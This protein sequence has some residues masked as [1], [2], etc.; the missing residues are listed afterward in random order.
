[1]L[2]AEDILGIAVWRDQ[3]L[4][5]S[6]LVRP[7]GRFRWH[8]IGEVTGSGLTAGELEGAIADQLKPAQEEGDS[9]LQVQL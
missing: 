6:Y 9:A 4:S 2:G 5:S 1:V 8:L 7:Q 3:R